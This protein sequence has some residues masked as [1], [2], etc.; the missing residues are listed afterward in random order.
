MSEAKDFF[1]SGLG[2]SELEEHARSLDASTRWAAVIELGE[3]GDE[4]A[5]SLVRELLTDPDE[6]VRTSAQSA[7]RKFDV[8]VLARAGL[9]FDSSKAGFEVCVPTR[10]RLRT[11]LDAPK[12]NSWKIRALPA[13]TK[14][15]QW[16]VDAALIEIIETETPL[17]GHRLIRLYGKAV[18]P[19]TP[20][21]V[22]RSGLQAA[23]GRL[24]DRNVIGRCDDLT[25]PY[26]DQWV[27]YRVGGPTVCVRQRGSRDLED[28]P[29]SEV[30][31]ALELMGARFARGR[32]DKDTAFQ[33]IFDF[34][35]IHQ[36]DFHVVGGLLTKE[37]AALLA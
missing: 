35:G 2:R 33:M 30:R 3:V 32:M 21:R 16:L 18:Y 36:R 24:I 37:W 20:S 31:A 12:H 19:D 25:A 6:F 26:L 14:D 17:T 10:R 7:I 23:A 1:S 15:N 29:A 22:S 27:L 4:W 9:E 11:H 28:I 5:A 34:Y 13:P 8:S